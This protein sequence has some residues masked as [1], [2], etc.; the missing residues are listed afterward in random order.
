MWASTDAASRPSSVSDFVDTAAWA[1][2]LNRGIGSSTDS[3]TYSRQL[4]GIANNKGEYIYGYLFRQN[5]GNQPGDYG[6]NGA[7]YDGRYVFDIPPANKTISYAR[8]TLPSYD[9]GTGLQANRIDITANFVDINA[10]IRA[11]TA[12]DIDVTITKDAVFAVNWLDKAF[13]TSLY[14]R[15]SFFDCVLDTACRN[16]N[17]LTPERNGLYKVSSSVLRYGVD[18]PKVTVTYDPISGHVSTAPIG[19]ASVGQSASSAH[20]QQQSRSGRPLQDRAVQ[21]HA[22]AQHQQ[23]ERPSARHPDGG[24]R[25]RLGRR[26]DPHHRPQQAGRCLASAHHLVGQAR[27]PGHCRAA[28]ELCR[29][30]LQG[31]Q[32]HCQWQRCRAD[33][34]RPAVRLA[35]PLDAQ[36]LGLTQLHQQHQLLVGCLRVGLDLQERRGHDRVDAVRLTAAPDLRPGQGGHDHISTLRESTSFAAPM[37]ATATRAQPAATG[38]S[39]PTS[40]C[41]RTPPCVPTSGWTS[42]S[43]ATRTAASPSARTPTPTSGRSI[44]NPTGT[45]T[46]KVTDGAR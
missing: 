8:N 45:T 17:G 34:L 13:G 21:R 37:W 23:P 46:I 7:W 43:R 35:L 26:R 30:H 28:P 25:R 20:P 3:V 4:Q 9:R 18:S 14:G 2:Y 10:P 16:L 32:P 22:Q 24:N 6:G 15:K 27:Q 19:S 42:A 38:G 39:R 5:L 1:Y 36:R 44:N 31:H 11:G 33:Q 12:R 29:C 40:R 41:T